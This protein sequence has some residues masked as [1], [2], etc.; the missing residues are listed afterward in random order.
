MRPTTTQLLGYG[1]LAVA[2]LVIGARWSAGS[3]QAGAATPEA[4]GRIQAGPARSSRPE[5]VVHVAGAVSRPGVYGLAPGSR[6]ADAVK[7]AGG[8]TRAG[9]VNAVNLAAPLGDGQQ[10]VIPEAGAAA[11]TTAAEGPISLGSATT[12][13]LEEIDGI[14]P[15]TAGQILAYR[16]SGKPISRIEDLEA[17]P[18]I[19]PVTIESLRARLQP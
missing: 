15:V 9:L 7:R 17:V 18:G 3:D 10:V 5:I 19:G 16:D 12:A 8:V 14:G 6:V 13:D 1:A 2:I 11:A 4:G